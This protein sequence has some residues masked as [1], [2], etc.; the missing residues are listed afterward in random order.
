M[1]AN[2][3]YHTTVMSYFPQSRNPNI[4]QTVTS[5]SAYTP[6]IADIIAIQLLYGKP[7]GANE[8]DTTYGV[9]ANTGT[10]LD[11]MFAEVDRA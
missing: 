3:S 10:Y 1:F 6:Q 4:V 11:E 9:G 8:G 2:D 5:A 7:A